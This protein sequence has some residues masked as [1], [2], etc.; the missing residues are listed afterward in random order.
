[1]SALPG[2]EG[3]GGSGVFAAVINLSTT[4]LASARTRLELLSN[5]IA[6]EKLR[7]LRLLV[8]AQTM[9]FCLGLAVVLTVG[10]LCVQFWDAR[11]FVLG[12]GVL[13]FLGAAFVAYR[14][15]RFYADRPQRIFDAS[16][17]ELQE[18]I[19]QLKVALVH[20]RQQ[21]TQ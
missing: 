19:R 8:A 6:E 4:L 20:E 3:G 5:E 1:M 14:F 11:L 21:K 18:D 9:L 13:F 12:L 15:V 10:W 7:T 2:N 16:I 17:A